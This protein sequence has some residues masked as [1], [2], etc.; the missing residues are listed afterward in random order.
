[1]T[2]LDPLTEPRPQ[3][4]GTIFCKLARVL[5][6]AVPFLCLHAAGPVEV[7][8]TASSIVLANDYLERTISIADGDIGTR[9][10]VNKITGRAYSLRGNEFEIKSNAE[11][12]GY[13]F[14]N[15]N[16][17]AITA[18]GAR[19]ASRNIEDTPAGGKRLT[20]HLAAR[21]ANIDLIY[22]LNPADFY[23]RQWIHIAKPQR[24]T[25]FL[26]WVAPASNEWGVPRFSLGGFGQPLFAEDL[27]LGLEYPTGHN[28]VTGSDVTLGS[29][30]GLNIPDGG[31][32]SEPAVIGV[33]P[34][35]MVH[36]QFLDYVSRMRVAPV[37]PYLLYNSWYDL[38]RLAMNHDNTLERVPTFQ[39]LLLGK[40]GLHLDSFV[41]D[42]GWDDMHKL[43]QIDQQR[44]PG[45]FTDLANALKTID[46][47]L[48]IWFGPIGGYDQ[49]DVRIAAAKA[50][51]TG[52]EISSDG[53]YFCTAGKNYSRLFSDT[54]LKYQK[55]YGI[56]YFK[57][58]GIV[59]GCNAPDHG[60]PQGVYSDEA[61]ARTFIDLL[62][63]LR[64]Q[65]PK[66]FLNITT[67]IWL[68]PWWLKYAD[69]VWMGGEDSGYLPSVPTLAQRQ[70][71][72][73]YRDSV[74][75]SDFVTHKTQFPISSLMTH[76]IIKGKANMLGGEKESIEDFRDEVV[77]YYSVG[78][79]MYELYISP[80]IL[81]SEE[82]DVLGNV[83]KWA[84]ANAHPLLDNSMMVGGDPAQREPYGYVH[85]N[86]EKS[87]VMLRNPF[88]R[89]RTMK[90]KI[91]EEN[92][93]AKFAGTQ[94][95]ELLY[96]ERR[97][98]AYPVKFGDSVAFDLD[99][100]E[101]IVAEMRPFASPLSYPPRAIG[102]QVTV[103]PAILDK[104]PTELKVSTTVDVP[105]DYL[106]ARVA[107]LLEPDQEVKGVKA[108]AV[109][110]GKPL[111]LSTENGGR[112]IW[113][114]YYADL[115]PGKHSVQLT[116]HSGSSAHVSVWLLTRRKTNVQPAA[117]A[118]LPAQSNIQRG[119][120]L[121]LEE[122]IR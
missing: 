61:T 92:G 96:P 13:N 115:T 81:S 27:F 68:S 122:T 33:A 117:A 66:V 99:S 15:E 80:E 19:V 73:S 7:R 72:I 89:P 93:F 100:Y 11:W 111:A 84:E 29:N 36:Q 62:G 39:K 79:M 64:A 88:V 121:L 106:Q 50:A 10:F 119:T 118:G 77:H 41:L 95:V 59:F 105:A 1:M 46:S 71:A 16:P 76:G 52:M 14:G 104:S 103:S 94:L 109:D 43:W 55:E 20:L 69:T 57:L 82:M 25:L 22:E 101:E 56:N 54:L 90:L 48:G 85:S 40:Y 26:E 6:L 75:Y 4:S 18:A 53:R 12:V 116:V 24:G 67:S 3:G 83:T 32:T 23:T 78:N 60:H 37:R 102:P 70:S 49:R 86:A 44:F 112:G 108:D 2:R 65:D 28:T 5:I 63:K 97:L 21:M 42:D 87:I 17:R 34:T 120:H 38:Q 30:V 9:Q 114:W 35:G 51:G 31:Y 47:H 107:I 8:T 91:D 98:A 74:L 45:G 110:G 113:Y 58:D